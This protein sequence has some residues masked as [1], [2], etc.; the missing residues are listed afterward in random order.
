MIPKS[1]GILK[2]GD[3]NPYLVMDYSYK[4]TAAQG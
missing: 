3:Y 4:K 2:K 1:R